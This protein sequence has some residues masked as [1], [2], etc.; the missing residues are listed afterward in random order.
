MLTAILLGQEHSQAQVKFHV[1]N[2]T[3]I[4]AREV[5]TACPSV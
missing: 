1:V 5:Q 3:D 2:R 4:K